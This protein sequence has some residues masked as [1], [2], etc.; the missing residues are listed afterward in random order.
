[1]TYLDAIHVVRHRVRDPHGTAHDVWLVMETLWRAAVTANLRGAFVA[2]EGSLRVEPRQQFYGPLS[3]MMPD[4]GR[5]L[6]FHDGS[7]NI[8]R[9]DWTRFQHVDGAWFRKVGPQ[10]QQWSYCGRD[11]LVLHPGLLDARVLEFHY[12]PVFPQPGAVTDTFPLPDQ[13]VPLA[14]D[15]AELKLLAKQRTI[16]PV[17]AGAFA[18][19]MGRTGANVEGHRPEAS[20]RTVQLA[21]GSDNE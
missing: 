5:I 12:A 10:V 14:L 6:A 17:W 8:P 16:G 3:E 15:I 9:V 20:R 1:V 19:T 4:V 7:H 18:R 2:Y 13:Y 21:G 11:M